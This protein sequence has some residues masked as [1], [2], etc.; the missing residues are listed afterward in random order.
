MTN[1]LWRYA[2]DKLLI[3]S[4]S[5]LSTQPQVEVIPFSDEMINA[6][7]GFQNLTKIDNETYLIGTSNG[8]ILLDKSKEALRTNYEIQI[9]SIQVHKIDHP[10]EMMSLI[11]EGDFKNKWNN[12]MF[13]YS[14]P[15]YKKITNNKY[16]YQL[17]GLSENW[18]DWEEEST[19]LFE[20]LPFG[21]YT[22]NVRGKIGDDE[23]TSNVASY[24]FSIA[25]PWFLSNLSI[26]LYVIGIIGIFFTLHKMYVSYYKKQKQELI[27]KAQKELELKEIEKEQERM[28]FKNDTLKKEIENKNRELAVSTMSIIK[29]NEFLSKLKKDLSSVKEISSINK[30]VNTID[31]NLNNK[32]DWEFFKKAFNNADKEFFKK[33]KAKHPSLTPND[34]KLCAYLRLNLSSK[35]IAS[36]LNISIRST[37]VKRYRLR[38]K[39]NLPHEASLNNYIIE[40]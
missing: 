2:D 22:F 9:N 36:L 18:S 26:V 35:E 3:V 16:Q 19:H 29:K 4:P 23:V 34:L 1:K 39:M 7:V 37:E 24:N 32:D 27:Q 8:Y 12:I 38:K 40:I 30:V 17:L 11:E 31:K 13:N 20:N 6:V 33:L 15:N 28:K 21:S 14:V 10:K 25:R 5:N